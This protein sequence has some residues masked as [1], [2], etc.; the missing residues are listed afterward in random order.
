MSKVTRKR[1]NPHIG[2]SLEDFLK[3]E[4]LL[5]ELEVQAIKEVIAYQL[6]QEMKIKRSPGR[7][8]PVCCVPAAP[9]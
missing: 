7:D 1:R 3:E 2:S 6:E 4:S 8:S 5:E 9:R